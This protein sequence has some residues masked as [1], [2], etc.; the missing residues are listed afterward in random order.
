[1]KRIAICKFY[2]ARSEMKRTSPE[3]K[4]N[5]KQAFS[6]QFRGRGDEVG[7]GGGGGGGICVLIDLARG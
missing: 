6:L 4:R 1:M 2:E 3:E 7:G 5:C